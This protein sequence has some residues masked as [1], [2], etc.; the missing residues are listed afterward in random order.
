M[1]KLTWLQKEGSGTKD[2]F[3]NLLI[4]VKVGF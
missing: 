2:L 1:L 4:S 3:L